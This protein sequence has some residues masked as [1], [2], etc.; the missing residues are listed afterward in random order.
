MHVPCA[1]RSD[2]HS[3]CVLDARSPCASHT[4]VHTPCASRTDACV[5]PGALLFA[6]AKDCVSKRTLLFTQQA[7]LQ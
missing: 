7:V 1:S 6:A 2:A 4:D 3:P 5:Y